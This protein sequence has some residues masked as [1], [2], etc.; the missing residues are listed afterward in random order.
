MAAH[1]DN[2]GMRAGREHD[3]PLASDIHRQPALVHQELV[4][5]PAIGGP[6]HVSGKAALETGYA[7]NFAA[8]VKQPV[9]EDSRLGRDNHFGAE[10]RKLG[11]AGHIV[12]PA[13]SAV[14][15]AQTP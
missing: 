12:H 10:I 5:L 15:P 3:Q 9:Q 6:L 8:D 13:H 1:V 4:R 14:G 2:A 7:R 11:N